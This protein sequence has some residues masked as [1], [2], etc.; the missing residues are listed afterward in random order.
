MDAKE[1]ATDFTT[2]LNTNQNEVKDL[3]RRTSTR[4]REREEE[5]EKLVFITK[6]MVENHIYQVVEIVNY[7]GGPQV[8]FDTL[9]G[10]FGLFAD[11]KY[12]KGEIITRYDGEKHNDDFDGD[13]AL[14]YNAN[15]TVDGHHGFWNNNKGRWIN[16]FDRERSFIN[17]SLSRVMRATTTIEEG[18][19][20]F[21]DYGDEYQRTY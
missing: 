21:T 3:Q 2:M 4:K 16:E 8:L 19:Q 18:D 7:F 14:R 11:R 15:L 20:L 10:C 5:S 9:R 6:E 1:F 17:V 13:Y 12:K